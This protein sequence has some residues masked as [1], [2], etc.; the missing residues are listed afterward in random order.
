MS[1]CGCHANNNEKENFVSLQDLSEQ[2]EK[3]L[4][5]ILP[6]AQ[7]VKDIG[8]ISAVVLV[9]KNNRLTV[10]QSRESERQTQQPV[11]LFMAQGIATSTTYEARW[12]GSACCAYEITNFSNGNTNVQKYKC[13]YYAEP[14]NGILYT[15]KKL[16]DGRCCIVWQEIIIGKGGNPDTTGPENIYD[17]A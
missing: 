4:Q 14:R 1:G 13:A 7:G 6:F 9:S 2:V 3:I 12:D 5:A 8:D 16:P 10:F 17:C 11:Q 15:I